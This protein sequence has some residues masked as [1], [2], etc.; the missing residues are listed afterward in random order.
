M[1]NEVCLTGKVK[2][3]RSEK[4]ALVF[5]VF[6]SEAEGGNRTGP[7]ATIKNMPMVE[8]IPQTPPPPEHHTLG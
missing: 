6:K 5:T 8:L 4:M 2:I 1:V 7:R 3:R